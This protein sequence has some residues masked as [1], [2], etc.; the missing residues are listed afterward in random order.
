MASILEKITQQDIYLSEYIKD[1]TKSD[2]N[3]LYNQL[4]ND[5]QRNIDN[6]K[7][8]YLQVIFEENVSKPKKLW[9]S[10]KS[11][12]YSDKRKQKSNIVLSIEDTL[13]LKLVIY[14]ITLTNS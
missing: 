8:N 6:A 5:V 9:K 1:K 4:R 3:I 11:L 14:A 7:L 12:G 2:L 13:V 10:L